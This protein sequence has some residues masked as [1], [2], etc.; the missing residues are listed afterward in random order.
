[1]QNS[2]VFECRIATGSFDI[3]S[4]DRGRSDATLR[5]KIAESFTEEII[6]KHLF[7]AP[8]VQIKLFSRVTGQ[9]LTTAALDDA[10]EIISQECANTA[11]ECL[12]VIVDTEARSFCPEVEEATHSAHGSPPLSPRCN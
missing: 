8:E 9:P 7:L 11:L 10:N 4:N 3:Q 1:M 2:T 5:R 12:R 6:I